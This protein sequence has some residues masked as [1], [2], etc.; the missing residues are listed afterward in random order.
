[1][2]TNN[3]AS[4]KIRQEKEND[5]KNWPCIFHI[6]APSVEFVDPSHWQVNFKQ[7]SGKNGQNH[8]I[9][10]PRLGNDGSATASACPRPLG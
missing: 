10:D 3:P 1:M 8:G 9:E 4:V 7:F 2:T 5:H 6:F